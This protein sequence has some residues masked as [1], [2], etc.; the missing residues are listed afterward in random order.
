MPPSWRRNR[1][2]L[3]PQRSLNQG[4]VCNC[5]MVDANI[6]ASCK[7]SLPVRCNFKL[8]GATPLIG[9]G[10]E[11]KSLRQTMSWEASARGCLR[12]AWIAYLLLFWSMRAPR[13]PTP[14]HTSFS[15]AQR[16]EICFKAAIGV[17]ICCGI[18]FGGSR[19]NFHWIVRRSFF[20]GGGT[21]AT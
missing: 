14:S 2:S 3:F 7:R 15:V 17:E 13:H 11:M 18:L 20:V 10:A 21:L 19:S 16:A 6:S 8:G 12:T 5:N 4:V 9:G 1:M